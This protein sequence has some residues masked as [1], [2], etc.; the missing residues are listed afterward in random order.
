MSSQLEQP[1]IPQQPLMVNPNTIMGQPQPPSHS[2]SHSHS[3]GSFGM[4]FIVL[5][6]ICVVSAIACFLGRFCNR[7]AKAYTG[8]KQPRSAVHHGHPTKEHDVEFGF[9]KKTGHENPKMPK[10]SSRVGQGPR[11]DKKNE[12][13]FSLDKKMRA[14]RSGYKPT[15]E[16]GFGSGPNDV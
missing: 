7:K 8:P 9:G 14:P 15:V 13:E 11:D 1:Y 5:V 2:H 3:D 10:Q 12:I 4:V 16:V 6:V